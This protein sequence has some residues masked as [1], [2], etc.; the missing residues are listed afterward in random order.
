[1]NKLDRYR[2]E[3]STL[4]VDMRNPP[5]PTFD[6]GL[7]LTL[8][9]RDPVT[10]AISIGTNLAKAG[11]AEQ[12]GLRMKE[13]LDSVNVP[14]IFLAEVTTACVDVLGSQLVE[15][16]FQADYILDLDIQ[17]YGVDADSPGSA[18]T[19]EMQVT[20]RILDNRSGDLLWERG[21]DMREQASP[22]MFGLSG[23]VGDF[24]NTAAIAGLTT[25][26]MIQGFENLARESARAV[27]NSLADDL[28]NARY[29]R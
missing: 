25:E 7:N 5:E 1:M 9:P 18:V 17:R 19:L 12:A 16:K 14:T 15:E 28:Y 2:V 23:V 21:F 13:A 20:A 22:S 11:Q 6:V 8:N 24:I 3:N 29:E 27:S 10:T 4:A 26:Q